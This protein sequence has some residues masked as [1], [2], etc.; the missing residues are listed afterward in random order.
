MARATQG[1]IGPSLQEKSIQLHT[2][3]RGGGGGPP[4][5]PGTSTPAGPGP[6]PSTGAPPGETGT[7]DTEDLANIKRLLVEAQFGYIVGLE[8]GKESTFKEA[9][10]RSWGNRK[11]SQIASKLLEKQKI[12]GPKRKDEKISALWKYYQNLA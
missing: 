10:S 6:A 11:L 1:S 3:Q 4:P 8:D 7:V 5:S 12:T 9:F 2:P